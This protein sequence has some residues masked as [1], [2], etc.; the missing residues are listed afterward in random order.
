MSPS[1]VKQA[2]L[3][4]RESG[5]GSTARPEQEDKALAVDRGF[6]HRWRSSWQAPTTMI[7]F[8][9]LSSAMAVGHHCFYLSLNGTTT[10]NNFSQQLNIAY[11]TAFA[12]V[13]KAYMVAAVVSAYTQY[14]WSDFRKTLI[15]IS[16]IASTFTATTSIVS[17]LDPRFL[18][19]CKTGAILAALVWYVHFFLWSNRAIL[20]PASYFPCQP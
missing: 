14:I 6:T 3:P 15:T 11:G 2:F 9:L 5:R 18:W 16:T 19:T 20:M 1:D 8:L 4:N 7:G 13:A 10:P 12:F 17:M